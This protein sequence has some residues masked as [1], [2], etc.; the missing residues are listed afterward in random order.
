MLGFMN[1][2]RS[3]PWKRHP[4]IPWVLSRTLFLKTLGIL[5]GGKLKSVYTR[6]DV[7]PKSYLLAR[8]SRSQPWEKL[9]EAHTLKLTDE[10]LKAAARKLPSSHKLSDVGMEQTLIVTFCTVVSIELPRSPLTTT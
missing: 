3:A 5:V 1:S 7:I 4:S 2:T 6:C 10:T 9:R 8:C